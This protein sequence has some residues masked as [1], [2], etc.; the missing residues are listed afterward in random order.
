M[1]THLVVFLM[2]VGLF[3]VGIP[4]NGPLDATLSNGQH[5]PAQ[6]ANLQ[7]T[8]E[9]VNV[10]VE[11]GGTNTG[12][13]R[14]EN[15][16]GEPGSANVTYLGDPGALTG[17]TI[18]LSTLE[19]TELVGG[20]H[21][22]IVVTVG[23]AAGLLPLGPRRLDLALMNGTT[24]LGTMHLDMYVVAPTSANT[25]AGVF[26]GLTPEMMLVS[27][28]ATAFVIAAVIVMRRR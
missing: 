7:F 14:V 25:G 23:A 8:A 21:Q 10:T 1:K 26:F 19:V 13:I 18:E 2:I 9:I 15:Y 16:G 17:M 12:L 3:L 11:Q 22:D 24:E 20:S 6:V 28:A 27:I 5:T 4:G